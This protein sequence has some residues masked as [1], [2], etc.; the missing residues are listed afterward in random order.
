MPWRM[1]SKKR[2]GVIVKLMLAAALVAGVTISGPSP[3]FAVASQAAGDAAGVDAFLGVRSIAVGVENV[4]RWRDM[5]ARHRRQLGGASAGAQR[6]RSL[7]AEL[8]RGSRESLLRRVNAAV[9]KVRY[10]SD[11]RNWHKA[12]HWET[13]AEF[14]ARGGDCEDYATTKYLLLRS[15]GVPA[16]SMR[17]LILGNN[18]WQPAHAVLVVM[19]GEEMTVLDNQRPAPY[20]LSA[21]ISSRAAYAL[22]ERQM[23]VRLDRGP[24]ADAL[25]HR[26]I[27]QE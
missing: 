16:S 4:D 26:R 21:R 18:A 24:V 7:A 25:R 11:S 15:L 10:V 14:L 19:Q 9:N 27:A 22:N 13:P 23:W 1:K 5:Y 8:R 3:A 2:H 12:D 6:W 17:M 20:R